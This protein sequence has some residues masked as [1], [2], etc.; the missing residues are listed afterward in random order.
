[1]LEMRPNCEICD[2]DLPAHAQTTSNAVSAGHQNV[3]G[4]TIEHPN[5]AQTG[6]S[7]F[8]GFNTTGANAPPTY[9]ERSQ[10][11]QYNQKESLAS[12][13]ADVLEDAKQRQI[14]RREEL[15][16]NGA[17]GKQ[18]YDPRHIQGYG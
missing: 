15:G 9:E 5:G 14:D 6:F 2:K 12:R 17:S 8:G 16:V 13:G 4:S 1:M 18:E 3:G 10:E 7:V 11:Q